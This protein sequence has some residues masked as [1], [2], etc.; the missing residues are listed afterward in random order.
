V[1]LHSSS[2]PACV[3]PYTRQCQ[4]SRNG[5]RPRRRSA[6]ASNVSRVANDRHN[7]IGFEQ[8]AVER[9]LAMHERKKNASSVKIASRLHFPPHSR[10]P[11]CSI[12]SCLM[13][14]VFNL[15]ARSAIPGKTS[16]VSGVYGWIQPF[17]CWMMHWNMMLSFV[18]QYPR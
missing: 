7:L 18:D 8:T 17:L 2:A 4:K 5:E 12:I 11:T 3:L 10:V 13:S 15:R 1:H 14:G 9:T 6:M 16:L